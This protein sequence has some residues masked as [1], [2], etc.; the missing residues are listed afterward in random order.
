MPCTNDRL[1]ASCAMDCT[2]RVTSLDGDIEK[3]FEV[4]EDRVK[5][6]D[7]ERRNPNLIFSASEDGSVKQIDIRTNE[8][9]I[10][11]VKVN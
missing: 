10:S 1:L 11:V 4:H 5:T 7:V 9:P 3:L 6:I 2:V 8:E